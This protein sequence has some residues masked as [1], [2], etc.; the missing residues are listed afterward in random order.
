MLI[1]TEILGGDPEHIKAQSD[2]V[3][4]MTNYNPTSTNVAVVLPKT[5]SDD[6]RWLQKYIKTEYADSFRLGIHNTDI[7]VSPDPTLHPSY[8]P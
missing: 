7:Q 8:T 2:L 3:N 5:R 6:I 1:L 4:K